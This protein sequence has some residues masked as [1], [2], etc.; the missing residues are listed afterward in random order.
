MKTHPAGQRIGYRRVSS[1]DQNLDRQLDG[2]Q[3]DRTFEDK[4]SG[5][6]AERPGL[7]ACLAYCRAGDTLIVHSIDRLARSVEDL[8]R[9]VREQTGKG[10]AIEFRK[11]NLRFAPGG[12]DP[13]AD[14]MLAVLGAI[15]Q[16][17]RSLI[18]ER[19][20]EGIAKAKAR[21]VYRGRSFALGA[22]QVA[23]AQRLVGEGVPKAAVARRLR[24]S[25]QTLHEYLNDPQRATAR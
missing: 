24:V 5:S 19:Q 21:G 8:A 23:E 9:I 6:T 10:V 18:R 15:G 4:A 13:M 2:E 16:F 14:L 12:R 20:R 25:R 1:T 7:V 22:E 11:E 17:E 3:L